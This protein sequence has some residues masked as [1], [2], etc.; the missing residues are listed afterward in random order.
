MLPSSVVAST[1]GGKCEL[2]LKRL[3]TEN[4][5]NETTSAQL[6]ALKSFGLPV[7]Q[8]DETQPRFIAA[9]NFNRYYQIYVQKESNWAVGFRFPY[10][11]PFGGTSIL[12]ETGELNSFFQHYLKYETQN[13][14]RM[15]LFGGPQLYGIAYI[16]QTN[17]VGLVVEDINHDLHP[18]E[19]HVKSGGATLGDLRAFDELATQI[20]EGGYLV[21][22]M[23]LSNVIRLKNGQLRPVDLMMYTWEEGIDRGSLPFI[24]ARHTLQDRQRLIRAIIENEGESEAL[25]NIPPYIKRLNEFLK[26]EPE[27]EF[28]D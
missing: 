16:K 12:S 23:K 15:A 25:T 18:L 14:S 10:D 4:L 6:V 26:Q 21:L 24:E 9:G 28:V 1:L 22:D 3:Q 2:I 11:L 5:A 20:H 17:Q 13:Y 27:P 19:E 7:F 8:F